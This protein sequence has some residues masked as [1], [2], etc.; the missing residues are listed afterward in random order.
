MSWY[1]LKALPRLFRQAS[2]EWVDDNAPRLGA[3][4]AFYTL[5]SLAPIVVIA[6]AVA[7]VVY[8][9][10]AA[11]GRLASEIRGMAGPVVAQTVQDL[12]IRAG[13]PRT[14]L[15]AT[16]LGLAALAFGATSVF[17]DLHDAM[18]TIWHVPDPFDQGHSATLLRL[19]R[20]RFYSFAAVL[21]I[22]FLL[23]L[24]LLL[25]TGIEALK[26]SPPRGVTFVILYMLIALLFAALYKI[27][28]DVSLK[29]SDVALG[30]MI[31]SLPF[32]L[33]KQL[34]GAYFAVTGFGSAYRAAGSPIVVLLWVYYSAQLFF[35]GAEFSKVYAKTLGSHRGGPN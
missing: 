29:W 9:Q 3:S 23:L 26:I 24:S 6:V 8:G 19:V 33:G 10:E 13:Q 15:I 22:G 12:L 5:L 11:E 30:A 35:W 1:S 7:A 4:A 16:L 2:G 32:T 27:L 28:P 18:N 21:G 31:T 17:V 20:R 34:I 14:G 25:N